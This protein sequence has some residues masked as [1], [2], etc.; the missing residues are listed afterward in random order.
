MLAW[1]MAY[2]PTQEG[3]AEEAIS[4]ESICV[5]SEPLFISPIYS[6]PSDEVQCTAGASAAV[7]KSRG[8]KA[9]G[10]KSVPYHPGEMLSKGALSSSYV[11]FSIDAGSVA[12]TVSCE[13]HEFGPESDCSTIDTEIPVNELTP[14]WQ[15]ASA[16]W[17]TSYSGSIHMVHNFDS[18][19]ATPW[20]DA[21]TASLMQAAAMQTCY[22][23]T[24]FVQCGQP[25]IGSN[26]HQIGRCKPCAFLYKMGCK[27][28]ASC[29]YC[30]LC[31]PG[32]KQRRKRV[33]LAMQ[34]KVAPQHP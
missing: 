17:S 16:D 13:V 2:R 32:E 8:R 23:P 10:A 1:P 29:Q 26:A 20:P 18:N 31:P 24:N 30:H 21:Y 34:Q 25:S 7:H 33:L 9:K 12:P 15:I 19:L 22:L 28:G 14:S 27:S 4:K 3:P 11:G 6:G 5:A